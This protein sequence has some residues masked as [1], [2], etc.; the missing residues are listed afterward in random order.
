MHAG[1]NLNEA[2][3]GPNNVIGM[4]NIIPKSGPNGEW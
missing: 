1:R 2:Y 3:D 4:P